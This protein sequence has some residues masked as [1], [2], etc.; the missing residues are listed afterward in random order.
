MAVL[1]QKIKSAVLRSLRHYHRAQNQGHHTIGR[2]EEGGVGGEVY[3]GLP[4]DDENRP[5]SVMGIVSN[6]MLGK[7]H[8]DNIRYVYTSVSKCTVCV[9]DAAMTFNLFSCTFPF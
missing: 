3:E 4:S 6:A 1:S 9:L 2:L 8:S 7:L 5:S